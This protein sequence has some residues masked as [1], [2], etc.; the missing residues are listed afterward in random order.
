MC[1]ILM[2]IKPKYSEKIFS[3]NKKYEFRRKVSKL[4]VDR[5]IVYSSSPEKKVIGEVEVMKIV[6]K[7]I[8]ELWELTKKFAGISF[9]DFKEYFSGCDIAYAYKLGKTIKYKKPKEL[10]DFNISFSPQS[11][12]Y[13]C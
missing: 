9:N 11:Y 13:I 2:S 10:L 12:V 7:P 6:S 5:I 4:Q 8:N 3:G 1:K